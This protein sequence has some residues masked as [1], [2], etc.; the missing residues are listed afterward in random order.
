MNFILRLTFLLFPFAS[1]AEE[2]LPL[3]SLPIFQYLPNGTALTNVKVPR[4]NEDMSPASLLTADEI[5]IVDKER[6]IMNAINAKLEVFEEEKS[7]KISLKQAKY[8]F[9]KHLLEADEELSLRSGA[10]RLSGKGAFFDLLTNQIFVKGPSKMSLI[11][12]K[13]TKLLATSIVSSVAI[14]SSYAEP[15]SPPS[16]QFKERLKESSKNSSKYLNTSSKE[17][18]LDQ[19]KINEKVEESDQKL[20]AFLEKGNLD[21]LLVK[22]EAPVQEKT[23]FSVPDGA[24]SVSCDGGMYFDAE[25]GHVVCLKNVIVTEPRFSLKCS[26]QLK[27]FLK[28]GEVKNDAE[29][30]L[31]GGFG[32]LELKEL[33][34]QGD[35]KISYQ[36]GA[37]QK[38]ISASGETAHFDA[39]SGEILLEGGLPTVKQGNNFF[40]ALE[41]TVWVKISKKGFL[42]G[43]GKKRTVY[44]NEED[45]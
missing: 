30:E 7:F 27:I 1:I 33:L 4:Y 9:Q 17:R 36:N 10:L 13:I 19:K 22:N 42:T 20:T 18:S 35:V 12:Q 34:A 38:P 24:L 15:P 32:D 6:G 44:L 14:M 37:E 8:H 21:H 29:N 41:P 31:L 25:E 11:P 40:E 2:V 3:E 45:E 16:E 26:E 23:A 5:K 43:P 28:K 39:V